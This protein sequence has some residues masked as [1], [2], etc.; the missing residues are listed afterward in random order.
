MSILALMF[1]FSGRIGRAQYWLGYAIQLALLAFGYICLLYGEEYHNILALAASLLIFL[2]SIWA[3]LSI[4]AKRYHD[5]D[6]SAWWILIGLIP[7]IGGIWQL[8]ELGCLRGTEGSNDY[9]PDPAHSSNIAED[10]DTLRRQAGHK[11]TASAGA[12]ARPAVAVKAQ[13]RSPYADGRP[14]FGKRV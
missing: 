2:P 11:G 14:V 6:K 10:I 7:I 12:V 13:M 8:I 9:G 1:S 4:M 5:R 3:G